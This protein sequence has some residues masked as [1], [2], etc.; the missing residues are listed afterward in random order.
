MNTNMDTKHVGEEDLVLY[1]YGETHEA[2]AIAAHLDACAACRA[3]Y[4]SL[5]AALGLVDEADR[6]ALPEDD[7][8]L[9]RDMWARLA[10]RL[11]ERERRAWWWPQ[12]RL[13]L[14]AVAVIVLTAFASGL[15]VGRWGP[16]AP[17][18]ASGP[19]GD[20]TRVLLV[21]MG[22]HLE[23]SQTLL[24]EI[25]NEPETTG[26]VDLGRQRERAAE[27]AASNRIYRRGA[28]E[29]GDAPV[30]DVLE[31]LERTLLDIA[32]APESAAGADIDELR[33]R[34]ERRGILI[35]IHVLGD[36][37]KNPPPTERR[38]PAKAAA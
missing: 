29:A 28:A 20:P 5:R 19:D 8:R 16:G 35:K 11:E 6:S 7:G 2:S 38:G 9:V 24:I 21:A 14:A 27:L 25:L 34:I 12:Q 10:P 33:R 26:A 31:E 15:L 3:E 32:N 23:R 13:A 37:E 22:D 17:A 1:H 4:A 36:A 18:T 30:A